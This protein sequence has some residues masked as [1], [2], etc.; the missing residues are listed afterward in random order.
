MLMLLTQGVPAPLALLARQGARTPRF[1][2][3]ERAT[4]SLGVHSLLPIV[5]VV[6]VVDGS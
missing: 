5:V 1:P 6:I 2:D 4:R 3:R